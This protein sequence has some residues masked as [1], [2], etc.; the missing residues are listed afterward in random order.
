MYNEAMDELFWVVGMIPDDIN[1]QIKEICLKENEDL[2]LSERFFKNSLHISMKRTFHCEYFEKM[3]EDLKHLL[4]SKGEIYCGH[5]HLIKIKDML[6][7]TLDEDEKI[8][9][10]HQKIDELLQNRYNVPIDT[11]DKNYLPHITIFHKGDPDNLL[12]MHERLLEKLPNK[13]IKISR[14]AIGSKIRENDIFDV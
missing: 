11:F 8:R 14:Y 4:T 10:V 12:K 1:D 13:E 9:K 5:T 3:K 6:W 2:R 7:L